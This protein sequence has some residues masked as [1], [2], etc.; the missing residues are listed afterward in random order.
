MER[1]TI[2][3]VLL[4]V[5]LFI[6]AVFSLPLFFPPASIAECNKIESSSYYY[7]NGERDACIENVAKL[8]NDPTLCQYSSD[9]ECSGEV[10]NSVPKPIAFAKE[11][12]DSPSIS[13]GW[14]SYVLNCALSGVGFKEYE[15]TSEYSD[16]HIDTSEVVFLGNCLATLQN[17]S[18]DECDAHEDDSEWEYTNYYEL[19]RMSSGLA[20]GKSFDEVCGLNS[21]YDCEDYYAILND[22]TSYCSND[23]CIMSITIKNDD[24]Y[25]CGLLWS[26][27]WQSNC[28]MYFAF[29]KNDIS[30]CDEMPDG[31]EQ[32]RAIVLAY[33]GT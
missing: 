11:L 5:I 12:H 26:D 28:F 31:K 2:F 9:Y 22:D 7:T 29:Q 8:K 10:R 17:A 33:E 23:E 27:Y 25:G 4:F 30:Y 16:E 13:S 15:Y 6:L 1:T 3:L 21:Y 32:C 18:E 24:P 14:G 20:K 19:C